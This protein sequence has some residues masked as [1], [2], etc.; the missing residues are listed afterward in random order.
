MSTNNPVPTILRFVKI[1]GIFIVLLFLFR[2]APF[3]TIPAG[4]VG[5]SS[6]FGKVDKEVLPEGFHIINPLKKVAKIDCRI[7]ELTED[8]IG[9]PSQDQLTTNI[10]VTVNWR[11][12]R[13]LASMAYQETGDEQQLETV[14]LIPRVRSLIREAGKGVV[15][16]EDFYKDNIQTA[17]QSRILE[18]LQQ[19]A[20]QGIIVS[21]VLMRRVELPQT[22][23]VGV[24]D[25]K[26]REQ[27][28]EQQKAEYDRFRTEQQQKIAQAEAER[29]A[30]DEQ[31]QQR[32][33]LADAKAYEI[34]AEAKARAE[35]IRIEGEALKDNP[36]LI[37]L[38]AV[39]KWS[40]TVPKVSLGNSA[41]P[42]INLNDIDK[43]E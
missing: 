24:D 15:K 28:A 12:N 9:V 37:R 16:A 31:V 39:E 30:A 42:L 13:S 25:K 21:D 5:V 6:L 1:F 19:L 43:T 23:R 33:A 26:R 4:H 11:V 10:D 22:V 8:D 41:I 29:K 40:G 38:R 35:A 32:K 3:T 36:H 7:K 18:S 20:P 14:L 34:T 17:M 27:L 2:F